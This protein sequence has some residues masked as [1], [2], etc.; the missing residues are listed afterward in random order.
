MLRP[1]LVRLVLTGWWMGEGGLT[2]VAERTF[3][4][5]MLGWPV[6]VAWRL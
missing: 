1:V 6:R 4:V 3:D 2:E 5:A